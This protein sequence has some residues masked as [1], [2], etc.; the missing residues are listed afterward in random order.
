MGKQLFVTVGSTKF[1]QLIQQFLPSNQTYSFLTSL[2]GFGYQKIVLQV[3]NSSFK[4]PDILNDI[5]EG[6]SLEI[7][8]FK[9]DLTEDYRN[10]DL[11]ISHAGSGSIL[12]SL[13]LRKR[14]V[15]V[16]NNTL[17]D[18]HQAELAEELEKNSYLLLCTPSGLGETITRLEK[19][20]AK[21]TFTPFPAQAENAL[22]ECLTDL[23]SSD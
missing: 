6:I 16:V 8:N 9:S 1:D 22:Q 15:V 12:E 19:D 4:N 10:A 17:A 5:V 21:I 2:R 20:S 14:L 23:L 18:N 3:G 13:R 11:I 7:Y